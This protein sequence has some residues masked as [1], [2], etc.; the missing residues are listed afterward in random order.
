[1]P[2][3]Q[4]DDADPVMTEDIDETIAE[5]RTFDQAR[6]RIKELSK[7]IAE[8]LKSP[9]SAHLSDDEVAEM[10]GWMPETV[11][12]QRTARRRAADRERAQAEKAEEEEDFA[13]T[14]VGALSPHKWLTARE[15]AH[16]AGLPRSR[17][18]TVRIGFALS[19]RDDVRAYPSS[20]KRYR[21]KSDPTGFDPPAGLTADQEF[22][23][24]ANL[25]I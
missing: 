18:V 17:A 6:Q 14:L 9:D 22:Y 12:L 2:H 11:A 3:V 21:L 20:P 15:V 23:L 13:R 25:S 1:M 16:A 19:K 10:I 4:R 5:Y 8:W 7:Q 24:P